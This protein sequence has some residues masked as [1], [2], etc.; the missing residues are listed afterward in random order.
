VA[1]ATEVSSSKCG[2]QSLGE[3]PQAQAPVAGLLSS[4]ARELAMIVG[5]QAWRKQTRMKLSALERRGRQ[6]LGGKTLIGRED[7][8]AKDRPPPK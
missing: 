5:V 2:R 4:R 8:D 3:A 1:R 6:W 7:F